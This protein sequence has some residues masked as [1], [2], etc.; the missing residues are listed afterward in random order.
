MTAKKRRGRG[1]SPPSE[2][3]AARERER[4]TPAKLPV[5]PDVGQLRDQSLPALP[6]P[7]G[8]GQSFRV[9]FAPEVHARLWQHAGENMGVEVCGVLVGT[10]GQDAGGPFVS[11]S[12]S[13]RGE[14][15][16]SK[17]AEVTFTHETWARINQE[18][19]TK[20]ANLSIVGWYHTHPDF[21]VF[22][23]DRDLFIQQHFFAG[24]GQ[25]AHVID[26]VRKIDGVFV[27]KG[28]Q[29]VLAPYFW[30]GDSMRVTTG[31]SESPRSAAA[32]PPTPSSESIPAG[33][34]TA[35]ALQWAIQ[36]LGGLLLFLLGYMLAGRLTEFERARLAEDSVAHSALLLGIKPGLREILEQC[37]NDLT[38][39]AR[40]ADALAV[41]EA[42]RLGELSDEQKEHWQS[43]RGGL[44][45]TRQR[46]RG[47]AQQFCLTPAETQRMLQYMATFLV[48]NREGLTAS[49][50]ARLA[51]DLEKLLSEAIK[52]GL[53]APP[54]SPQETPPAEAKGESK[55]DEKK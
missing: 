50:R 16:T 45:K 12:E 26:P 28:G 2:P 35:T 39:S 19:D 7:A 23:S 1:S 36:I 20:F 11:I 30:V 40:E 10:W 3:T 44:A 31:G 25:I 4:M 34:R 37:L 46:L 22:L 29:T 9:Y 52:D 38:T 49:E 54:P 48:M 33:D 41:D 27:W 18:M 6:F 21:G 53:P 42:K 55:K 43:L 51:R 32:S 24:P 13:I 15:A 47:A 5:G 8:P 14:A 17:F